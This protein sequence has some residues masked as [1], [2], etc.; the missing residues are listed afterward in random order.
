VNG[1]LAIYR[2]EMLSLW[3]TPLAWVLMA[4]FL[5]LQGL[6]F[7]LT[8]SHFANYPD[9]AFQGGPIQAYF[10]QSMFMPLSILLVAPALTMRTFAEERR[11]GTLEALLTAPVTAAGVVAGKYLASLSTY[12]LLWLPT[13]LYVVI[14]RDTGHIDWAVVGASYLAVLGIGAAYLAIGTLMSALTRSQLT[15]LMLSFFALFG[16]LIAGIGEFVFP[17][18]LLQELCAHVS[19]I[20]QIEEMSR[21]VVDSRRLVFDATLVLLPLLLTTRVVEV[22]R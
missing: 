17:P 15:A 19:V 14:L 13:I 20:G 21:G 9:V 10:G 11:S 2:R 7:H 1:A 8:L 12:V 22:W 16:S 3:V 5:V 18:G 6:S 4:A